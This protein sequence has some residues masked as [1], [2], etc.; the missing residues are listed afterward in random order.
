MS[1]P[2]LN[3]VRGNPNSQDILSNLR[4]DIFINL[5]CHALATV[6]SFN[7]ANQTIQGTINYTKTIY[8]KVT[9]PK[10]INNVL[11]QPTYIQY[12][13]LIDVP[14][15]VMSGGASNLTMPIQKGDQCLIFFNDREIDSWFS[16]GGQQTNLSVYRLHSFADG[17]AIVGL[18]PTGKSIP[19][20]DATRALLR[21]NG[22]AQV[23]VNPSNSLINLQNNITSLK[24]V[25]NGFIDLYSN[26]LD[27][28]G[29]VLDPVYKGTVL[30]YK[31]I[32]ESLLE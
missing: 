19:N 14:V 13:T 5:N 18:F 2:S 25:I 27:N 31:T 12:P 3:I 26:F 23:G 4:D 8:E 20:Y 32:V 21:E 22:G 9:D 16:G 17:I 24:N 30:A 6:F 29:D 7:P 1:T 11:Y 10:Q 15:I 28:N